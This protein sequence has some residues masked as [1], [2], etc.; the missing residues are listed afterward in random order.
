MRLFLCAFS[1]ALVLVAADNARES[2]YSGSTYRTYTPGAMPDSV[3]TADFNNDGKM[4]F[5]VADHTAKIAVF[6]NKGDG[7]FAEPE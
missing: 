7:T 5:A 6:A 3:A 2:M 4:D 1:M